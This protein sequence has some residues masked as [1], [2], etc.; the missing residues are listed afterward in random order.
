MSRRIKMNWINKH[1]GKSHIEVSSSL[2][3]ITETACG[4]ELERAFVRREK[5]AFDSPPENACGTCLR[6]LETAEEY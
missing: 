6:M 2:V 5:R 1:N 4:R 3:L